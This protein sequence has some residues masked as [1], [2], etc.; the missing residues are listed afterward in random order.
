VP[1]QEDFVFCPRCGAEILTACPS[2]HCAVQT[3]WTH[4]PYCGTDLLAGKT[5][6]S[7]QSHS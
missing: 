1:T 5:E 7:T 2:C 3:D 6:I 4:C